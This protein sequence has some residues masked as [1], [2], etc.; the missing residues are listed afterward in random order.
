MEEEKAQKRAHH[1]AQLD[2]K[3]EES[4]DARRRHLNRRLAFEK[5]LA[6]SKTRLATTG[7]QLEAMMQ[8]KTLAQQC[9][10]LRDQLRFR[11]LLYGIRKPI[12]IGSGSSDAEL[13]RLK[14]G[15]EPLVEQPLPDKMKS[16]S[17]PI[18]ARQPV[19]I[20]SEQSREL[21]SKHVVRQFQAFQQFVQLTKGGVFRL[22]PL[23][24][25]ADDRAT[26]PRQP[27][28]RQLRPRRPN[29]QEEGLVGQEFADEE[30]WW[31]VLLCEW[32]EEYECI[33]V[34][35]YDLHWA[36]DEKLTEEQLKG[37]LEHDCVQFSK[38]DEVTKWINAAEA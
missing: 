7:P 6:D 33:I 1:A 3:Q 19:A 28:P 14:Q 4:A 5:S 26:T 31:K 29:R 25:E 34:Y 12:L 27:R 9:E 38:V 22:P 32:S 15:V 11:E 37:D 23:H 36:E 16:A 20:P 10:A 21:T 30:V 8:G 18:P 24:S 35:Y 2:R 13:V 17:L